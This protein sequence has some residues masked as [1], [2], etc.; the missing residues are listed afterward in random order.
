[1]GKSANSSLRRAPKPSGPSSDDATQSQW[2]A[3]QICRSF[4]PT[5]RVTVAWGIAPE[6]VVQKGLFWPKAI[7][8]V[9]RGRRVRLAFGQTQT[10]PQ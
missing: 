2:G 7:F 8:T 6:N 10:Q 5:A 9:A 1:M 3:F 4:W